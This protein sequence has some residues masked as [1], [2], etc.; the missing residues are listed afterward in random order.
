M[1]VRVSHLQRSLKACSNMKETEHSCIS[2]FN[3]TDT[4]RKA[5]LPGR[6]YHFGRKEPADIILA[7]KTVSKESITLYVG[8]YNPSEGQHQPPTLRLHAH[9]RLVRII[10]FGRENE[11]LED[12]ESFVGEAVNPDSDRMLSAGEIVLVTKSAPSVR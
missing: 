8:L 6:E 7:D 10:P 3:L 9:K 11:W 5:L 2:D 12:K 1:A 4:F